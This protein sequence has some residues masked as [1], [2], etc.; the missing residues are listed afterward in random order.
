M[1]LLT[2]ADKAFIESQYYAG[3]TA[4]EVQ[5]KFKRDRKQ[6]MSLSTVPQWLNRVKTEFEESC[7][8]ERKVSFCAH[9]ASSSP[10]S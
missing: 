1:T 7:T 5:R 10:N 4:G 2:P 8:L 6:N 3:K 9:L